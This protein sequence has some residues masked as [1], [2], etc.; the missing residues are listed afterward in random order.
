MSETIMCGCDLHDATMV[1][2]IAAGAGDAV[3]R[4]MPTADREGLLDWLRGFARQHGGERIVFAY[5]ASGR[6]FGLCDFLRDAGVECYV[7]APTH[8][9]RTSKSRKTKTDDNDAAMLLDELRAHVLAGRPLP[10]VW[11]PDL[12]TRDDRELV[13]HRLGTAERRT[14]V[15]NQIHGLLKRWQVER[16]S[17][18]SKS[19][20]WSKRSVA[21][22]EERIDARPAGGEPPTESMTAE[23]P[24]GDGT[25]GEGARIALSDLAGLYRELTERIKSLDKAIERLATTER[26]ARPFRKLKILPGV[27]TLTAMTFLTELG[28]LDRFG[29]RRQLAAY[30][31]LAPSTFE[32]GERSDRKGH[33]TRQGP[34]RVRHVLCQAAWAAMRCSP[35]WREKYDRIKRG[36]KSRTKIA[37]V[38][39][40]RQLGVTMWHA[41]RSEEWDAALDERDERDASARTRQK[42]SAPSAPP[43][44]RPNGREVEATATRKGLATTASGN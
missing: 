12:A 35:T 37:I 13:R 6:G 19:G 1:L 25:L 15:K 40:M 3:R 14:R 23:T 8:L 39:I 17:W 43:P 9:P 31:G 11:V 26:Y 44:P 18:F 10:T 28:D 34:A 36:S 30:L 16:P 29:N 27:G 33:I 7:L 38:A 21:W 42:G 41:A 20:D 22:L 2:R 5:E 32:S 4:S 24:A